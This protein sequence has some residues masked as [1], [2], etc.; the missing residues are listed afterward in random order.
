MNG[1]V[2]DTKA[3]GIDD[4]IGVTHT[5]S[6]ALAIAKVTFGQIARQMIG[7]DAAINAQN[8]ALHYREIPFDRICAPKAAANVF[9]D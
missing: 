2:D 9:L 4:D 5:K 7:A 8:A 6:F 3:R 1:F